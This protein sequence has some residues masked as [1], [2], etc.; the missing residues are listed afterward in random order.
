MDL[1]SAIKTLKEMSVAANAPMETVMAVVQI[2]RET[3]AKENALRRSS[4]EEIATIES[5]LDKLFAKNPDTE[6]TTKELAREL[7]VSPKKQGNLARIS[8]RAKMLRLEH[9]QRLQAAE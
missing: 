9:Q 3:T 1:L 6:L 7:K 5:G 2:D 8:R 4:E